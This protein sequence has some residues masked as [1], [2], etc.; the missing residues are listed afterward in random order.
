VVTFSFT[1][2]LAGAGCLRYAH[3]D[4]LS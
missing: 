4:L 2:S 3:R 1:L